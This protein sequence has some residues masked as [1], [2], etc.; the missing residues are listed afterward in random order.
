MVVADRIVVGCLFLEAPLK[1]IKSCIVAERGCD[2]GP[3]RGEIAHVVLKAPLL[4][5]T[6]F[7]AEV[8][9]RPELVD[10]WA[11]ACG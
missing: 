6:P 9:A 3:L 1:L 4:L 10:A 2:H 7:G 5:R 11:V 8:S